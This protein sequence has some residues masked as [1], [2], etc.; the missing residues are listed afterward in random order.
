MEFGLV[1]TRAK[2]WSRARTG[3]TGKGNPLAG[4]DS[5]TTPVPREMG[6]DEMTPG[7]SAF[8]KGY[9]RGLISSNCKFSSLSRQHLHAEP[10]AAP[11]HRAG[12]AQPGATLLLAGHRNSGLGHNEPNPNHLERLERTLPPPKPAASPAFLYAGQQLK[13]PRKGPLRPPSRT[14]TQTAPRPRP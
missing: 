10:A 5:R 14:P 7:K 8:G 6:G 2:E 12:N 9:L 3:W 1:G 11:S 4:H 13:P